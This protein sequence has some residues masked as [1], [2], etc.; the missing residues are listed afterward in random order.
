MALLL[1]VFVAL[2][3]GLSAVQGNDMAIKMA[4]S[5]D[6]GGCNGCGG[7]SDDDRLGGACSS[8]CT[9]PVQALLTPAFPV[10]AADQQ[11]LSLAEFW[12]PHGLVPSPNPNPP[13][14]LDLG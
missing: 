9:T 3:M 14:P 7:E 13:K 8:V 2:G 12:P 10:I 11:K 5:S 4:M 1:G 6:M